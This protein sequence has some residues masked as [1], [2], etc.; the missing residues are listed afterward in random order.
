MRSS[1]R[2]TQ[3]SWRSAVVPE[4]CAAP[5]R[6]RPSVRSVIGVDPS[7]T[8]LQRARELAAGVPRLRFQEGDGRA[9]GMA[10]ASCDVVIFSIRRFAT[11]P[12]RGGRFP[13]PID[14]CGRA[15]LWRFSMAITQ[16]RRSPSRPTDPLQYRVRRWRRFVM[17]L[18]SPR[19][20]LQTQA[21]SVK[22]GRSCRAGYCALRG[23]PGVHI[24]PDRSRRGRTCG[25]RNH[26]P[27]LA[28]AL[29]GEAR[30][31]VEERKY[32]FGQ[33]RAITTPSD[34][35]RASSLP[36]QDSCNSDR[37]QSAADFHAV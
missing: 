36:R 7:P 2:L 23:K 29:K 4:R 9:T 14:C 32:Y 28:D 3:M 33:N 17:R 10:D 20:D 21:S 12:N 34:T 16:R 27:T 22:T 13:R 8:L 6:G 30:V 25:C 24:E 37:G 19:R 11:C 15:E 18:G 26:P 5:S 35:S 1:F 31:R